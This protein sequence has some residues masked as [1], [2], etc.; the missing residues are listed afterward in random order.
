MLETNAAGV[1][2]ANLMPDADGVVRRMPMALRLDQGLVPGM[3]A[4]VLRVANG[5]SD[6]TMIGNE[7]DPLSF[8]SGIGLAA[9]ETEDR[10]GADRSQ[11]GASGC[12]M[13]PMFPGE[14]STP[15]TLPSRTAERRDR[16]G[17]RAR[18]R[19]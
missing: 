7:H 5:A 15:G 2:A 14:S 3:A 19:W 1:A 4:E 10:P 6:I 16:A 18:A 8:L 9:L 17:G 11:A 12:T 13:P